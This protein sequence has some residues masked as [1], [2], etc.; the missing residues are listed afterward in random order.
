MSHFKSFDWGCGVTKRDL[1]K[2]DETRVPL[3]S[4][5]LLEVQ[6][7]IGMFLRFGETL[8]RLVPTPFLL[9]P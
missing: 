4:G 9:Y 1:P 6:P 3:F 2:V 8:S 5:N 7:A